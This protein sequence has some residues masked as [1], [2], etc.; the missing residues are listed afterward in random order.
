[1]TARTGTGGRA[2]RTLVQM[3]S[4]VVLAPLP[5]RAVFYSDTGTALAE[6][7]VQSNPINTHPKEPLQQ[8]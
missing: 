4:D 1:M 5:G 8:N 6:R 2:G 7:M 3:A